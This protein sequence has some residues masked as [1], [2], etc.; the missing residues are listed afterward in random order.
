LVCEEVAVLLVVVV[1]EEDRMGSVEEADAGV[2]ELVLVVV[3]ALEEVVTEVEVTVEVLVVVV[4]I[5]E[6]V[7]VLLVDVVVRFV[8]MRDGNCNWNVT[9]ALALPV[10]FTAMVTGSLPEGL[11]SGIGIS[12]GMPESA[13]TPLAAAP[14]LFSPLASIAMAEELLVAV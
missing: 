5:V 10:L 14:V 2:E 6:V 11:I 7:W 9:T 13:M 12:V 3:E 4:V 1:N 8:A